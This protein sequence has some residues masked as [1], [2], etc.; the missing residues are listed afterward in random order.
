MRQV[1]ASDGPENLPANDPLSLH[2]SILRATASFL[3]NRLQ[4]TDHHTRSITLREI[5]IYIY[6]YLSLVMMKIFYGI[7]KFRYMCIY[8]EKSWKTSK[9]DWDDTMNIIVRGCDELGTLLSSRVSPRKEATYEQGPTRSREGCKMSRRPFKIHNF[10]EIFK[11]LS[12]FLCFFR[13]SYKTFAQSCI[14]FR[15]FDPKDK[16]FTD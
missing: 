11:K 9:F 4:I 13:I 3:P 12:K 15:S 1:R 7:T 16:K 6:L 10:P 2:S 8:D 5:G 14:L